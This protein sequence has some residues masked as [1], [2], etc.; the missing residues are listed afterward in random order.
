MG[1]MGVLQMSTR[2]CKEGESGEGSFTGGIPSGET[3]GP[4]MFIFA[5]WLMR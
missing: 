5:F 2:T 4:Q 1:Y 3:V